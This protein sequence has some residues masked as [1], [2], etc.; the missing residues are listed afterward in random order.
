MKNFA[1]L[2]G[3]FAA[4]AIAVLAANSPAYAQQVYKPT[5]Q[6]LKEQQLL[7]ALKPGGTVNGR[8]SIPDQR[9]ANLIQ[10]EGRDWQTY[11]RSTLPTVGA[12]AI[13]GMLV[14]LA[15]FFL[16]RGRIRLERGFSGRLITR[17]PS[18]ERFVHWTTASCFIVLALSGLNITFGRALLE[19]L[20]GEAGF[21][22]LSHWAKLSH[23]YL[24]FP[25]MLGVALMF[26]VWVK[27][28]IPGPSDIKWLAAGGGILKKGEHPPARRFNAG[29]KGIFWIVVIGGALMSISGWHLLF[30]SEGV[31]E[32]QFQSKIHGI[33]GMIFIAVMI[34]HIYIGSLGME[35]AFDAMGT[36][37]VDENWA[38][39]HHSLWLQEQKAKQAQAGKTAPPGAV[40][41]E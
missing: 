37:Q 21:G 3:V 25:F 18:F 11:R 5:E 4:I 13:L 40:A 27:D 15:L 35:G 6:A 32:I 1:R 26:L 17:F 2:M 36:G 30:P 33:V 38:A 22:T 9:A 41:A 14:L 34:A 19:P 28:N 10:P 29:Q 39:E 16:V 20:I 31:T 7:D 24:A 23:N 12:I 8:V